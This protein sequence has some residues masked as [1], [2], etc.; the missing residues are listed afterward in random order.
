M[1]QSTAVMVRFLHLCNAEEC[2]VITFGY[3]SLKLLGGRAVEIVGN[4]GFDS[5]LPS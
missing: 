4:N 5:Y 3:N 2:G 1:G